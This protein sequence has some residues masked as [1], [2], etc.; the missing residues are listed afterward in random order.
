[1]YASH[2]KRVLDFTIAII[3]FVLLLPLSIIMAMLLF[4][5]YRGNPF[6]TQRRPGLNGKIFYILKFRTMNESKDK[7][8]NLLPDAVRMTKLGRFIRKYS[9]DEIPQLI[10][11]IK[12]EMSLV[13][14]RPQL[15]EF[16][17]LYDETQLQRH[18]VRPGITGWAQ[19]NGRNAITWTKR[20]ELD[21]WYVENISFKLDAKIV[22]MT[23]KIV[24]KGAGVNAGEN[25]TMER[26][27]GYN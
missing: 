10:N 8:G 23:I 21:I 18:K 13:G 12:G 9:L 14:P 25:I 3:G 20:F 5:I 17:K 7:D 4:L 24:I 11:V 22:W 2:L 1:M 27:N 19:V 26:F 15:E 16:L 6:F